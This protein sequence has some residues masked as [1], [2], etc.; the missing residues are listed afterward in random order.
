MNRKK[1]RRIVAARAIAEPAKGGRPT[2][3]TPEF[4]RKFLKLLEDGVSPEIAVRACGV[5]PASYYEWMKA[6]KEEEGADGPLR[7]FRN[8]VI[9]ARAKAQVF[10]VQVIAK[11]ARKGNLQAAIFYL[12]RTD[13]VRWGRQDRLKVESSVRQDDLLQLMRQMAGAVQDNITD[14]KALVRIRAAWLA[15][16]AQQYP[17]AVAEA[18]GV[19]DAPQIA[20]GDRASDAAPLDPPPADSPVVEAAL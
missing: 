11:A 8:R 20:A 15:I 12:E 18:V 19:V 2:A 16:L 6:G 4:E 5:H 9:C 13:P 10:Y 14:Q 7:A 3:R 17:E 1:G